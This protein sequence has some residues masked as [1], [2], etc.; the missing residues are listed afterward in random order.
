MFDKL[1]ESSKQ[2]QG[3]RSIRYFLVTTL[4]YGLAVVVFASVTIIGFNP[5]LAEEFSLAA[6]LAPPPPP[7]GPPPPSIVQQTAGMTP[8]SNIFAPPVRPTDIPPATDAY[9]Y[10]VV[11]SGPTLAGAPPGSGGGGS[12][13]GGGDSGEPIP[14]PPPRPTPKIEPGSTPETAQGPRKV[15]EGVLQ[16]RAI[17]KVKPAYPTIARSIR[18]SGPVQVFVVIAEDGR[19]IEAAPMNGHPTLRSAAVEAA[20]QWLFTP[21]TLTGVP[22]KVQG[23]LTFNFVLE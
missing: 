17:K 8:V 16:G 2:G 6:M 22:V 13:P 12:T 1:V 14:P 3:R 4:I 21:T 19:V 7:A 15:S 10:Q 20:R 5:A 9:K 23:V 18:A 11:V